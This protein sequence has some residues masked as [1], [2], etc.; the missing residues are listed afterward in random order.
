MTTPPPAQ[1]VRP[2]FRTVPAHV[3]EALESWLGSPILKVEAQQA[4]FSP[5]VAARLRTA[6]N[7][8]V[9]VKIAGPT[10]NSGLPGIYRRE[11]RITS[12]LPADAPVPRLL[13]TYDANDWVVL[14]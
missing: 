13:W 1:G 2:D 12:A 11:I 9:F 6:D 14:A 5:G 10:P 8:A 7:R 3:R 4:G